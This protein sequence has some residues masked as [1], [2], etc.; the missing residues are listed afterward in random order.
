MDI[1]QYIIDGRESIRTALQKMN[2]GGQGFIAVYEDNRVYGIITDGDVRRAILEGVDLSATVVSI[3]NRGFRYLETFDRT[4][5]EE[6]FTKTPVR[7][8]PIIQNG[9]LVEVIFEE[10][11]F[12]GTEKIDKQ[13][14]ALDVPLVIMAGGKGTRLYPYTKV[15]P[16]ALVPVHGRPIIEMIIDR[17]KEYSL[18][19]IYISVNHKAGMIRAYFEDIK[20]N[21]ISIRFVQEDQPL[22]TAG[23]LSLMK[24]CLDK[25]F[26]L[27]NCDILVKADYREVLG[28]HRQNAFA[29]TIVGALL[30]HRLPYGVCQIKNGGT[31]ISLVEKQQNDYLVNTGM[32]VISP[33]VLSLI[34]EDTHLDMNKLITMVQKAGHS[35]GVFP[36]PQSAWIDIGQINNYN[37]LLEKE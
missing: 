1:E 23:A 2:A 4:K 28:F 21:D 6:I 31:L 10:T 35:V 14:A 7:H 13:S 32:Y 22:G 8:L 25:D 18:H 5:V 19:S 11:F 29:I 15:L 20:R 3:A 26:F 12:L 33:Q 30:H 27:S 17:F 34:P 16:K 36:I 9:Q 24:S 37:Q